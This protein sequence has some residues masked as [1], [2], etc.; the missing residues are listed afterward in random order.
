MNTLNT[1][2][3][4][5]ADVP[6]EKAIPVQDE[7]PAETVIEEGKTVGT[8]FADDPKFKL[9]N[10]EVFYGEDRAIKN[11]SLDIARNE[12]IAFIGPS[13]CGKSTFLRCLNRM[14]DSI[15]I[16]RVK[17]SLQ[18]D[19]QNIYDSKRDVVELRAR[20]GMVFQKPNPFPKSIYDNVAYGP[21]I[22]GLANRKSDLD[23]IVENSLRKA[24]LWNEVK[25]RLDATATGMS[26]GQQQRLCIARAIAVSPEVVLMDEPCSALD[27]IATAKVEELIAEL[28]ESYTIVIVTH[29]MQQ[30]ARVSHRTAYFHLGHLVEVNETDKVFTSPEHELTESYITGRFG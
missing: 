26:G 5:E 27:P 14:N 15:D 7:R 13:G 11:I 25:D 6:E 3:T 4:S 18:L 19:D 28:S 17:G 24:G 30:A 22:H 16:C 12:V 8:P 2:V 23:D 21:R 1:T 10:V 9:R 20:V 29:S